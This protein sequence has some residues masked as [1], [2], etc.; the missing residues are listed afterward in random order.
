MSVIDSLVCP[1]HRLPLARR[2]D[3]LTCAS[4]CEYPIVK[5]VPFLLP[6]DISHTHSGISARSFELAQAIL[7][8]ARAW[9]DDTTADGIDPFVQ[10]MVAATN[11][12]LYRPV[13]GQLS[14][15]PIPIFPMRA[16]RS[17]DLLLDIGSGW[18]RWCIAASRAGFSPVGIDP[19]LESALAAK[20]VACHFGVEAT[21]VVGDSRYMPFAAQTFD[22]AF[23]YSVLQHF[24]E[25]DVKA[26]LRSLAAVM[27]PGGVSKLHML[28]RYGARSMQVQLFRRFREVG[29]FDTRY[30]SPAEMREQF[31]SILG[32]SSLEVDGFFVQARY[33][34][35]RLLRPR[36]RALVELSHALTTVAKAVPPLQNAADNLFV[37]SQVRSRPAD[38]CLNP[39]RT[40]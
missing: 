40:D 31:T 21:F 9:D 36:H 13:I 24:S 33:E 3:I 35:R 15:Y 14:E 20:R 17:G 1:V 6:K 2:A 28:N 34:D 18:G 8:G 23:S 39:S 37:V 11:S 27:K 19:S 7:T 4:G 26:T 22:T 25:D 30:W 32:P 29:G 5:G 10:N 12:I 16:R 38:G